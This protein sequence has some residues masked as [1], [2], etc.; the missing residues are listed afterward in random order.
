MLRRWR[1]RGLQARLSTE[2]QGGSEW[3]HLYFPIFVAPIAT[4][5][6]TVPKKRSAAKMMR[7]SKLNEAFRAK[8]LNEANAISTSDILEEGSASPAV[9]LPEKAV[10]HTADSTPCTLEIPAAANLRQPPTDTGTDTG[11][12]VSLPTREG[13]QKKAGKNTITT[14]NSQSAHPNRPA[15]KKQT[16]LTSYLQKKATDTSR[17]ETPSGVSG[18][19]EGGVV[20]TLFIPTLLNSLQ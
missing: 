19:G 5:S 1:E 2:I 16:K 11:R 15:G 4:D 7:Q 20:Y 9:L 14:N 12:D 6:K 18:G 17:P 3:V 13:V 8:K 10:N